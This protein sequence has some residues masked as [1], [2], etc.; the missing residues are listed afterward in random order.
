MSTKRDPEAQPTYSI[1][2]VSRLTGINPETLRVWERRYQ[3]AIPARSGARKS[4]F[5][6]QQ[7]VD[8]LSLVKALVDAGHPV[9]SLARLSADELRTRIEA[10]S[11]R[12]LA[13]AKPNATPCRVVVLG[14]ALPARL[15]AQKSQLAGIDIVGAF[16][17]ASEFDEKV[18]ALAPELILLEYATLQP[19]TLAHVT[20]HLA[21]AGARHAV[22]I[23]GFGAQSTVKAFERAGVV[24][25][26][27]PAS[28]PAIQRACAVA[29]GVAVEVGGAM[30]AGPGDVPPRR[31]NADQLARIAAK[32]PSVKCEC[33]H[34]LVGLINSLV[35]FEIY[36]SEC[37]NLN[38]EDRQ[39]HAL[40]HSMTASSRALMESA[41]TRLLEFEGITAD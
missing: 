41:L 22:V 20:R 19:E 37:E 29:R 32:V 5:Y 1:G 2:V 34:H 8:R 17:G 3:M 39:I 6:S 18:K 27:A 30:D 14:D 16:R 26:Q 31:F 11:G 12:P 38:P 24:C 7:D 9:S 40:L 35:A 36:S 10:S 4:R 25:L 15:A 33:P 28:V 23:F 13:A 21:S